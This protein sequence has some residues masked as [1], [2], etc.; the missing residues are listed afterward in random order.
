MML[1]QIV[2]IHAAAVG[3]SPTFQHTATCACSQNARAHTHTHLGNIQTVL[4]ILCIQPSYN[5][6]IHKYEFKYYVSKIDQ[7][8]QEVVCE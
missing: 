6:H 5:D 4:F 7:H 3:T 2:C 1:P 8:S